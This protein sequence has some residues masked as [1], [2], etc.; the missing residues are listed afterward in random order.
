MSTTTSFWRI[1][2]TLPLTIEPC[3][4]SAK[5]LLA[6]SS[7]ITLLI[8]F[9]LS[10]HLHGTGWLLVCFQ[11]PKLPHRNG[12]GRHWKKFKPHFSQK[13]CPPASLFLKKWLRTPPLRI[14]LF[15][16]ET[17]RDAECFLHLKTQRRLSTKRR[18]VRVVCALA[19]S[20]RLTNASF[21]TSLSHFLQLPH[22]F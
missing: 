21:R 10:F 13:Y 12:T 16:T 3:L 2:I 18:F 6:S 1:S 15:F 22:W 5:L 4:S 8:I 17:F 20:H 9:L 19:L 7:S 11:R 14:F